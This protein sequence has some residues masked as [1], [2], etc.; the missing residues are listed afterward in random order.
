V[1]KTSIEMEGIKQETEKEICLSANV[2]IED[3]N[4]RT[5]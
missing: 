5:Q 1:S 3:G 4:L 2:Y